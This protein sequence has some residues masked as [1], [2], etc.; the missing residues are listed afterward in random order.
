[1]RR[2][3]QATPEREAELQAAYARHRLAVPSLPRTVAP[4]LVAGVLNA[5]LRRRLAPTVEVLARRD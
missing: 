4:S 5:R 3:P 2:H 1:M